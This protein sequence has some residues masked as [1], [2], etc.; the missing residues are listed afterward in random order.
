V[1]DELHNLAPAGRTALRIPTDRRPPPPDAFAA[2]GRDSWIVP[3]CVVTHP[4]WIEVGES[5]IVMENGNL[6]VDE[7]VSAPKLVLGDGVRLARFTTIVCRVGVVLEENVAGSDSAMLF[8]CWHH[9]GL[10]LPPGSSMAPD[11]GPIIVEAG[12]YLGFN[13]IV[14]PGVRIGRGAFV[15]EGAVVTDDVPAHAVVY[16]NPAVVVR[17]LNQHTGNWE[18]EDRP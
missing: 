7:G 8:D 10:P 6:L 17:R 3:P 1:G 18:G 13:S 15:G 5:V 4:E 2:F 11:G 9:P 12:A 16:G 14:Y